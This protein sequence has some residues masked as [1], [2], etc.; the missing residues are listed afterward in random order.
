[1]DDIVSFLCND[2]VILQSDDNI[3]VL[4]AIQKSVDDEIDT[5]F[6]VI[7]E[8]NPPCTFDRMTKNSL[9]IEFK[10]FLEVAC[11]ESM[12]AKVIKVDEQGQKCMLSY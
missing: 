9:L 6:E 2:S 11:Y 1:M 3:V 5:K 4:T 12:P 8:T 10:T 7:T